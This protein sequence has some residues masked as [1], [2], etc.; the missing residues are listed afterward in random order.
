[1]TTI[2]TDEKFWYIVSKQKEWAELCKTQQHEKML[3][4][5]RICREYQEIRRRRLGQSIRVPK[6]T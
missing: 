6:T 5:R 4:Q 1:M 2:L 3:E